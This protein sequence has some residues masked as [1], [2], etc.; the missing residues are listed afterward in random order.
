MFFKLNTSGP[1]AVA[2]RLAGKQASAEQIDAVMN[3]LHLKDP[4]YKQYW[5]FLNGYPGEDD[6]NG[7]PV[8]KGVLPIHFAWPLSDMTV[9]TPDLGYSYINQQP[10]NEILKSAF[11]I[12]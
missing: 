11:P 1:R 6:P 12:T 2:A 5:Y 9:H 7:L 4:L 3:R 8:N 10:V